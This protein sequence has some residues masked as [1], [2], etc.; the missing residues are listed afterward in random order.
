MCTADPVFTKCKEVLED[1]RRFENLSW[2]LWYRQSRGARQHEQPTLAQPTEPDSQR[3]PSK[4]KAQNVLILA[5]LSEPELSTDESTCSEDGESDRAPSRSSIVDGDRPR[6]RNAFTAVIPSPE[7]DAAWDEQIADLARKARMRS[8]EPTVTVPEGTH[9]AVRDALLSGGGSSVSSAVHPSS[10]STTGT[11]T[12]RAQGRRSRANS[13]RSENEASKPL[14]Q[15][16]L[17]STEGNASEKASTQHTPNKAQ[18]P[19]P[20]ENPP[21]HPESTSQTPT[22]RARSPL[23]LQSAEPQEARA[24][25]KRSDSRLQMRHRSATT[26]QLATARTRRAQGSR[27]QKSQERLAQRAPGKATGATRAQVMQMLAMTNAESSK[28]PVEEKPK[29]KPKKKRAPIVFTTGGDEGSDDEDLKPAP[30]KEEDEW[31]E[32]DEEEEKRLRAAERAAARRKRKE[33]EERERI[34]MFKKRPIRSMSLADLSAAKKPEASSTLEAEQSHPTRGLLSTLFHAPSDQQRRASTATQGAIKNRPGRSATV[35]TRNP[36]SGRTLTF[37]APPQHPAQRSES[38]NSSTTSQHVDL[39]AARRN[40]ATPHTQ[41]GSRSKSAIALPLLNLTSL[42]STTGR[43]SVEVQRLPSTTSLA[44]GDS[45]NTPDEEAHAPE[46]T[47]SSTALARLVA[48]TQRGGDT[49]GTIDPKPAKPGRTASL[50]DS[51]RSS[52]TLSRTSSQTWSTPEE[53][54]PSLEVRPEHDEPQ[55]YFNLKRVPQTNSPNPHDFS[56][57]RQVQSMSQLPIPTPPPL[58]SPRTTRQNMLRDELSESLR[59]NLMWERQSR[60]RLLGLRMPSEESSGAST[61]VAPRRSMSQCAPSTDAELRRNE[62]Q[63]FHHKGW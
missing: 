48:L 14:A 6:S 19:A 20:S 26:T 12:P 63:S 32:V 23:P 11:V 41:M 13:L 56:S 31:C 5:P 54:G 43:S 27:H 49:L 10:V 21:T 30:P 62:E 40:S 33:E 51:R 28:E 47:K 25:E 52:E 37:A 18:P 61:P 8:A 46:R 42:R 29:P 4:S 15:K 55:D 16:P 22:P 53:I 35:K 44:S 60:A 50:F 39:T 3:Q 59:Q 24:T 1:G 38:R 34:E 9:E 7:H 45:P 36:M 57:P 17:T 2:R 58:Q